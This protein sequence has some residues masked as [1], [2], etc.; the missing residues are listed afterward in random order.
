M[1]PRNAFSSHPRMHDNDLHAAYLQASLFLCSPVLS[2]PAVEAE[3]LLKC[4]DLSARGCETA[5]RL[6]L[7]PSYQ[8]TP[9]Q[10]YIC[11]VFGITL[12]RCLIIQA[13]ILPLSQTTRVISNC[14]SALAIYSRDLGSES[15]GGACLKVW[16]GMCDRY[17]SVVEGRTTTS[18]AAIARLLQHLSSCGPE[19]VK[20]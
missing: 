12:L 2:L 10:A 17:F 11:F 20:L 8:A 13:Q 1:S 16:E 4:A 6:C 14:S 18:S 7:S 5:L 19:N 3:L 9:I 15:A